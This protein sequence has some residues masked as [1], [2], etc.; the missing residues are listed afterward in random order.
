MEEQKKPETGSEDV[1]SGQ[2]DPEH[3]M[4]QGFEAFE[5][6]F[7]DEEN[8]E[9]GEEDVSLH[10]LKE[11]DRLAG[12]RPMVSR[13]VDIRP[14]GRAEGSGILI[15][16]RIKHPDGAAEDYLLRVS[17][18]LQKASHSGAGTSSDGY[19]A[20]DR[21]PDGNSHLEIDILDGRNTLIY[22]EGEGTEE[23]ETQGAGETEPV[24]W[25]DRLFSFWRTKS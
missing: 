3:Q 15:P 5:E 8:V 12:R 10:A 7:S 9:Y 14:S 22:D 13:R 21:D 4:E 17:I 24:N 18:S 25:W 19:S 20:S 11:E 1:H 2:S 23:E 6:M 16:L